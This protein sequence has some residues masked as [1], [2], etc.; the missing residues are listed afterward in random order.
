VTSGQLQPDCDTPDCRN[1]FCRWCGATCTVCSPCGRSALQRQSTMPAEC[2]VPRH[3]EAIQQGGT[4]KAIQQSREHTANE[5]ATC[6]ADCHLICVT[7]TKM[8]TL[9]R[10]A[11]CVLSGHQLPSKPAAAITVRLEQPHRDCDLREWT[12]RHAWPA[13]AAQQA[14][15]ICLSSWLVTSLGIPNTASAFD[16]CQRDLS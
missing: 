2:A 7:L 1:S 15:G 10:R 9:H 3:P 5:D 6:A 13:C 4:S 12:C 8:A 14:W 16:C 11:A